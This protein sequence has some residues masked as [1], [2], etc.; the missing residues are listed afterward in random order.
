[1]KHSQSTKILNFPKINSPDMTK[2]DI[3]LKQKSKYRRDLIQEMKKEDS[4]SNKSRSMSRKR[5]PLQ[6]ARSRKL[7]PIQS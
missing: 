1:M 3:C 6:S 4:L 7:E 5:S 2:V